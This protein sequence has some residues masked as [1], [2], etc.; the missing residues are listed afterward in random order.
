MTGQQIIPRYLLNRACSQFDTITNLSHGAFKAIVP[1][2]HGQKL[3][4]GETAPQ[5]VDEIER[6]EVRDTG[7]PPTVGYAVTQ[8]WSHSVVFRQKQNNH[9][10]QDVADES[11]RTSVTSLQISQQK[12]QSNNDAP[13]GNTGTSVGESHWNNRSVGDWLNVAAVLFHVRQNGVVVRVEDGTGDGR[14]LRAVGGSVDI[15]ACRNTT[16]PPLATTS[17]HILSRESRQEA[18]SICSGRTLVKM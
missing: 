14:N 2:R 1:R 10:G 16:H 4:S 11:K 8:L 13:G 17:A 6:V 3:K 7:G 18:R 15:V 9:V 5:I 12:K